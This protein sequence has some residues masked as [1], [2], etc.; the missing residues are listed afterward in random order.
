MGNY[1][2]LVARTGEAT[3]RHKGLSIFIV[4][5]TAPGLTI[6]PLNAMNG[7]APCALF[8]DDMRLPADALIGEVDGGWSV[9]TY[10]LAQERMQGIRAPSARDSP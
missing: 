5:M 3:S 4:P 10:A 6:R 2:W 1:L 7:E 9:I 8:M